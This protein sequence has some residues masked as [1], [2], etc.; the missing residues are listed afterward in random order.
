MRIASCQIFISAFKT[1]IFGLRRMLWKTW[2]VY[3]WFPYGT[4]SYIE[5]GTIWPQ[6]KM[7]MLDNQAKW[8]RN[9]INRRKWGNNKELSNMDLSKSRTDMFYVFWSYACKLAKAFYNFSYKFSSTFVW[10]EDQLF[11][12]LLLKKKMCI[13]CIDKIAI[14]NVHFN[15]NFDIF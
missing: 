13:F 10:R 5:N 2:D 7:E 3:F 12:R 14:M 1:G 11:L 15:G 8:V 6:I 4:C 9:I